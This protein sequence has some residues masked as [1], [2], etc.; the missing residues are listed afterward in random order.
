MENNSL[1]G[2]KINNSNK[3][4]ERTMRARYLQRI[5]GL[6][7]CL[8][9]WASQYSEFGSST[10]WNNTEL[11]ADNLM[12]LINEMSHDAAQIDK[13]SVPF[14]KQMELVLSKIA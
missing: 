5:N 7:K 13:E 12:N 4:S 3:T 11:N 9:L 2:D 6:G 14:W 8:V 10:P 1:K